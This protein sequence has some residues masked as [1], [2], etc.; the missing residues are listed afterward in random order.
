MS[1]ISPCEICDELMGGTRGLAVWPKMAGPTSST[2]VVAENEAYVGL[3]T[4]GP[5][6]RGHCLILPRAHRLSMSSDDQHSRRLLTD[7]YRRLV[8]QMRA[9]YGKPVL[10]FEHGAS[11]GSDLRPCTV[12]HAH[13]HLV[14]TEIEAE[15]LLLV[16]YSWHECPDPWV[17]PNGEYLFIGDTCGRYW[18]TFPK[19]RIPSQSLRRALAERMGSSLSWDWRSEP[20][21]ELALTT[22]S[23]FRTAEERQRMSVVAHS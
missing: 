12:S 3:V 18:V 1:E 13:W 20:A 16:E 15:E 14:P 4:L 22:L 2:R 10:L 23:D 21:V 8:A 17:R 19:S 6:A 7:L 5:I 9:I 11:E